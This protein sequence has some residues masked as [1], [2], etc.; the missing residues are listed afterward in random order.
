MT[1]IRVKKDK[2]FFAASNV[3]FND[4]NLSWEARGVMG[5]LL[6]KPD[7]WQVRFVDLVKRGPAG[8]HKIR[9]I[10][11]ELEDNGYLYRERF[12]TEAGT[13][14]WVSTVYETPTIYQKSVD[15]DTIYGFSVD[16]DPTGSPTISRLSIDGS[17]IDGLS[18]DGKPRDILNTESINTKQINT[19]LKEGAATESDNGRHIDKEAYKQRIANAIKRGADRDYELKEAIETQFRISPNWDTRNARAFVQW[20]KIRPDS[21]SIDDFAHWWWNSDWRGKKGEPP[22]LVQIQ[23]LW[24][25]AFIDP[26]EIADKRTRND[27]RSRS[28]YSEWDNLGK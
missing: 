6:S 11:K 19:E 23:E 22:S 1:V 8:G 27:E 7:D 10:L 2:N 24:P 15:G 14:D 25:Q 26:Q 20:L 5:Y 12:Q 21:Q 13:F 18:I 17:S 28:R 4:E 3:P 16:G 9:R